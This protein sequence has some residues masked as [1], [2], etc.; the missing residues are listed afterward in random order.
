MNRNG[1]VFIMRITAAQAV[2][3]VMKENKSDVIF[4]IPGGQTLF[5][6]DEMLK[7]DMKFIATRHEGGAGHAADAW[8]RLTGNPGICLATTGPGA[9]NLVTPLGGALRDSSPVIAMVF[10][11]TAP[12]IGRDAAQDANHEAIFSSIVKKVISV[13]HPDAV[14]WAVREAYRTAL[15]GKKGPV[16]LDLYRDVIEKGECEYEYKSPDNYIFKSVAVPPTEGIEKAAELIAKTNRA[17]IWSGNGV[18]SSDAGSYVLALAEKQNIPII[19]TFNGIASVPADHALVYGS[20]SRHG[21]RLARKVL[22]E[23]ELVIVLGSSLSCVATGRWSLNLK[24]VIQVDIEAAIIGKQYPAEIGL[25][26][27]VKNT[28]EKIIDVLPELKQEVKEKRADWLKELDEYKALW[29]KEIRGGRISD[30]KASPTPPVAFADAMNTMLR[31]DTILCIDAGNPG[32]WSQLFNIK[33]GMKYMKPV[34][35]GNMAISLP[36]AISASIAYPDRDI[37]CVLGDGSLGMSL[38]ELETASRTGANITIIVLNDDAY[39]NIKQEQLY[40]MKEARYIGVDFQPIDYS[41]AAKALNC[42]G[43]SVSKA[44][45]I[46]AAVE[47]SRKYKGPY[48]INVV[49]DGSFTVWP[50]AF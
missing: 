20:R 43:E 25:V 13:R 36:A 7:A 12:E 30:Q 8:G 46:P 17:A 21:S 44:E 14:V 39:G 4:G 42:G 27:E 15:T 35:Y 11:N 22:E 47:R 41:L 48:L 34:N 24:K 5:V 31:N 29:Y 32:A 9:T 6:T 18:K 19:T 28:L 2:V 3:A 40:K 26:G 49:F 33:E 1:G 23:A 38:G 10:Q 45:D 16:V 50:E 37:I